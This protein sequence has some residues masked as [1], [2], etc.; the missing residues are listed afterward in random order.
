MEAD[1]GTFYV[2][3]EGAQGGMRGSPPLPTPPPP[4]P[5]PLLH[6]VAAKQHCTNFTKHKI[7]TKFHKIPG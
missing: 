4:P 1:I 7:L 6:R 5:P 3:A 2:S